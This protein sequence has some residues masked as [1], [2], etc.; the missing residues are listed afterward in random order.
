VNGEKPEALRC[1]VCGAPLSYKPGHEV[2]TCEYCHTPVRVGTDGKAVV[3]EKAGSEGSPAEVVSQVADA[4]ENVSEVVSNVTTLASLPMRL[5]Y[6]IR[7]IATGCLLAIVLIVVAGFL[8]FF[9]LVR[10]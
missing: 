5:L 9:F 10:R 8:T 4:V 7:P 1:P 2:L 3:E 6:A